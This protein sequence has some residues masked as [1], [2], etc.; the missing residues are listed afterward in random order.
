MVLRVCVHAFEKNMGEKVAEHFHHQQELETG[1]E[2]ME[3]KSL[4]DLVTVQ[5]MVA[6]A[7]GYW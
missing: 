5:T 3:S 2:M 1:H 7:A 6:A 4:V